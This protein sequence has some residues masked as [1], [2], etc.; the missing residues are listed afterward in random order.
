VGYVLIRRRQ[1]N[2]HKNVMLAA[3]AVSCIFLAVYLWHHAVHG[4]VVFQGSGLAFPIYYSLLA[5]H[6][7]L[8][9]TVP[10]LAVITIWLGLKND[11][12][13]H[14]WFAKITFP[15]WLYVSITGVIV[16]LM[17]YVVF[18]GGG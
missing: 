8:A 17:N 1:V 5:S 11:R 7:I 15:I 10:F 14:R 12:P 2:A 13:R 18:P 6:V 9:A 16:Y 3:F 4:S